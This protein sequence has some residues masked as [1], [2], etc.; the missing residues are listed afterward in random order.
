MST[1]NETMFDQDLDNIS[2]EELIRRLQEKELEKLNI[3]QQ[4]E[5]IVKER[6]EETH[7]SSPHL[8]PS[9][10]NSPPLPT[11]PPRVSSPPPQTLPP[12]DLNAISSILLATLAPVRLNPFGGSRNENV[13]SWI[14]EARG[15]LNHEVKH[16]IYARDPM[17]LLRTNLVGKARDWFWSQEEI[18]VNTP[19]KLFTA[20][21]LR[22]G[23]NI[24]PSE[25]EKEFTQIRQY[26]GEKATDFEE[27]VR[28]AGTRWDPNIPEHKLISSFKTGLLHIDDRK[29]VEG[30]R[31][32]NQA[33]AMAQRR[34]NY[35]EIKAREN[36]RDKLT[37]TS[38]KRIQHSLPQLVLPLHQA[39]QQSHC[40][41]CSDSTSFSPNQPNEVL[42][43]NNQ[44]QNSYHPTSRTNKECFY[45][46]KIG[47]FKDECRK[48]I[49]D[50]K[51]RFHPYLRKPTSNFN[52][53]RVPIRNQNQTWRNS[54]NS[55][56]TNQQQQANNRQS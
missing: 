42:A 8:F 16:S 14:M 40:S 1:E 11:S 27:R 24:D 45:C 21:R 6:I 2:R 30:A 43:I 19:E 3:Q 34:E 36:E 38:E 52:S 15:V 22:F 20:L 39:S 32:L 25:L 13:E 37:K 9:F 55:E 29:A 51:S 56:S 4:L 18:D 35:K 44:P 28:R 46:H 50:Q 49:H 54:R 23:S 53:N 47:H 41:H 12:S 7:R 31:T 26:Q 33:L 5:K 48:R 17:V 10:R